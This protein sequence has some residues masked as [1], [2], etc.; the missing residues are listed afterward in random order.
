MKLF[1]S[2][3]DHYKALL[4]LKAAFT[5]SHTFVLGATCSL[6]GKITIFKHSHIKGSRGKPLMFHWWTT[7]LP[8]GPSN[9][10]NIMHKPRF[11]LN[12]FFI[13][14]TNGL[15]KPNWNI[16]SSKLIIILSV[17]FLVNFLSA[18]SLWLCWDINFW[19][20]A[21]TCIQMP[22]PVHRWRWCRAMLAA[23]SVPCLGL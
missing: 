16:T 7:T 19:I 8:A 1:C 20:G 6:S 17:Y 3:S 14:L 15:R 2:L 11:R 12:A 5:Y 10:Q 22:C 18:H 4:Q 23:I 9:K 21:S 13:L